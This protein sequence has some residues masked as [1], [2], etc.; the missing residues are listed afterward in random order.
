MGNKSKGKQYSNVIAIRK[1]RFIARYNTNPCNFLPGFML[2]R[3]YKMDIYQKQLEAL[4]GQSIFAINEMRPPE[5]HIVWP[6]NHVS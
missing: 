6:V 4:A 2:K 3:L 1:A 5:A